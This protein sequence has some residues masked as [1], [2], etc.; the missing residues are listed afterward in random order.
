MLGDTRP[1]L[2]DRYNDILA[3]ID[4]KERIAKMQKLAL[5]IEVLTVW[6]GVVYPLRLYGVNSRV[7][8]LSGP[9]GFSTLALHRAR[10]AR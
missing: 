5:D 3:T 9:V 6:F 1:D 10:A 2:L 7:A 4:N 8:K